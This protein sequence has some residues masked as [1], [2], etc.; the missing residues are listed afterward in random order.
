MAAKKPA[1]QNKVKRN[2]NK[3]A[4]RPVVHLDYLRVYHE[5]LKHEEV[6]DIDLDVIFQGTIKVLEENL[7]DKKLSQEPNGYDVEVLV[8]LVMEELVDKRK[9]ALSAIYEELTG[10]EI[11]PITNKFTGNPILNIKEKEIPS[12][13]NGTGWTN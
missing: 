10:M 6:L 12:A 1:K 3:P 9:P 11:D 7:V 13:L 5:V 2:L 4:P 8:S